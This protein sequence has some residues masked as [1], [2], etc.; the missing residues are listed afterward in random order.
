MHPALSFTIVAAAGVAALAAPRWRPP[1]RVLGHLG[2]LG[3]LVPLALGALL[4]PVLHVIDA[5]TLRVL[6]PAAVIAA[7][8]AG[9]TA[10]ARGEWGALARSPVKPLIIAAARWAAL[11]VATGV[12]VWLAARRVAPLAAAWVPLAAT[13]ATLAAAA[14]GDRRDTASVAERGMAAGM[15]VVAVTL[16]GVFF[17]SRQSVSGASVGWHYWLVLTP[18]LGA[19]FGLASVGAARLAPALS[20]PR[21]LAD[22]G[23]LVLA[24]G[25]GA[26]TSVSPFVVCG[27]AAGAAATAAPNTPLRLRLEAHAPVWRAVLGLC[28]GLWLRVPSVWL[29]ALAA[30]VAL[31]RPAADWA[32]SRA[33]RG[34]NVP[35]PPLDI[36]AL[37][38]GVNAALMG[39]P[40]GAALLGTVAL[41]LPL[42]GLASRRGP[43]EVAG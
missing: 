31:L 8:W 39:G 10:G 14:A 36:L 22:A 40:G 9:A 6:A 17:H 26:A 13:A 21:G 35:L 38:I 2:D 30:A 24:A 16:V 18:T 27:L 32:L 41:A 11:A 29:L 28:A 23:L 25:V 15:T 4:S 3:V 33:A 12:L 20:L 42:S 37:G 34:A 19:V 7:G 5:A 1:A 43:A